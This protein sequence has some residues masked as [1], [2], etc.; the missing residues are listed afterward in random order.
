MANRLTDKELANLE[1][2]A[3]D[4]NSKAQGLLLMRLSHVA[5]ALLAE[6]QDARRNRFLRAV[7][8]APP[9]VVVSTR[10]E[11]SVDGVHWHPLGDEDRSPENGIDWPALAGELA[12]VLDGLINRR[13]DG[14]IEITPSWTFEKIR[15]AESVVAKARAAGALR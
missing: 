10:M 8:I 1:T 13:D 14:S 5:A 15:A 6:V 7:A 4:S 9:G 12:V 3:R 11:G 2:L